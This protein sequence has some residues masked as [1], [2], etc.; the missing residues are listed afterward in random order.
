M[1]KRAKKQVPLVLRAL[2][3]ISGKERC[4]ATTEVA[5][6]VSDI[7]YSSFTALGELGLL[8]LLRKQ[9]RSRFLCDSSPPTPSP[10][11]QNG[12]KVKQISSCQTDL[13]QGFSSPEE[14]APFSKAPKGAYMG[15]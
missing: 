13:S 15:Y 5:C 4:W 7:R 12:V 9:L 10:R 6:G 8:R 14:G 11:R 3:V 1:F 2:G